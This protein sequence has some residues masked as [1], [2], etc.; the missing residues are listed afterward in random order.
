MPE[1]PDLTVYV[2]AL[3]ARTVGRTLVGVR[4]GNPFVLRSADPPLREVHGRKVEAARLLGKRIVLDLEGGLHLVLHLMILGRLAWKPSD[5]KLAGKAALAAF[6]FEG[7]TLLFT[8]SGGKHRASLHLVRSE[9]L[10]VFDAG[11]IDPRVASLD[12]FASALRRENHTLKRALTDPRIVAGV[13]NAYSDEILHRARLSPLA[14]TG[15]LPHAEVARLHSAM[16]EVL[17][18]WTDR[19]R[20]E[21]K[22]GFPA[23]VTAFRPEM[24][25]HGKYGEPCPRCGS[26]VMKIAKADN[27]ANYCATCQTGGKVLADR[28]MS[29]LLNKDWPRTV[30]EWEQRM[31][32]GT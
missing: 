2:E 25:V 1:L 16:R 17:S 12:A 3:A 11:G 20:A 7:G 10:P 8:E 24:A 19:L 27:E 18:E 15:A 14:L 21:A 6:D 31:R 30:D 13:G 28:A 26:P 9:E 4:I 29:K 23:K 32:P 22:G 5:A